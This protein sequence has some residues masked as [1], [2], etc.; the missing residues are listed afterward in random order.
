MG[1]PKNYDELVRDYWK[2][3]EAYFRMRGAGAYKEDAL[4]DFFERCVKVDILSRYNP[5]GGPFDKFF[6]VYVKR[7]Y[8]G[9]V[10]NILQK[11]QRW[12]GTPVAEFL[13]DELVTDNYH[14]YHALEAREELKEIREFVASLEPYRI[15]HAPAPKSW[16]EVFDEMI[17]G[18]LED[19]NLHARHVVAGRV[20]GERLGVP[21]VHATA[22][23]TELEKRIRG[24]GRS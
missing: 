14:E 10:E 1:E 21:K 11:Q 15:P 23:M 7:S 3:T 22:W 6:F 9:I 24:R 5:E 16:L 2:W 13:E 20:L 12:G 17:L 18:H 8:W 19:D 4:Q